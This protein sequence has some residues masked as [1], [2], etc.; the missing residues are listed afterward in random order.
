M[1]SSE[2]YGL[3][4]R[5]TFSKAERVPTNEGILV[6]PN[7]G[8]R[9]SLKDAESPSEDCSATFRYPP[10]AEDFA[11][12][13][14]VPTKPLS[15]KMSESLWPFA[16]RRF[17]QA[18]SWPL[19]VAQAKGQETRAVVYRAKPC[20]EHFSANVWIQLCLATF[21]GML[22]G[23][24]FMVVVFRM[25][26]VKTVKRADKTAQASGTLQE[27]EVLF[28]SRTGERFHL[29]RHCTGLR[30]ASGQVRNLTP[31]RLCA[32]RGALG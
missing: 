12:F 7:Q 11:L 2:P 29:I 15:R 13:C 19:L 31:C 25:K 22:C 21:C 14:P 9:P 23:V 16:A 26:T 27:V 32:S 30:S 28:V 20:D 5:H 8:A 3:R 17:W 18:F 4:A 6:A 1:A 10:G 24:L